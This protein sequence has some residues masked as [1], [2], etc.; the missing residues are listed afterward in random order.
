MKKLIL[1]FKGYDSWDRPVYECNDRFYVDVNP[2][3]TSNPKIC[4]KYNNEFDG[5]PDTPIKEDI[6]VEF[7]P[8]REVWR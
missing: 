5:E 2:L 1:T 8:K 3:S 7:V 4:T 6:E